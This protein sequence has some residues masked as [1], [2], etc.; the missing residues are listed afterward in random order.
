VTT[1]FDSSV[2]PPQPS[3]KLKQR[4]ADGEKTCP[5]CDRVFNVRG[6]G[7]HEQACRRIHQEEEPAPGI[8]DT[9]GGTYPE[10]GENG[11]P[12]V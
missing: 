6:F 11:M 2:M 7:R 4:P 5:Y 3:V 8:I 1:I 12:H 9:E 10:P